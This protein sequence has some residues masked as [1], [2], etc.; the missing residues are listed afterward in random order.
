ML[1]VVYKGVASPLLFKMLDKWGNSN[2][3]ERIDLEN[4]FIRLFATDCLDSLMAVREFVGD[5]W[6]KYLNDNKIPYYIRT[7]NDFKVFI[8]HKNKEVKAWW[9]FNN[10]KAKELLHYPKIVRV[11]IQLYYPSGCKQSSKTGGVDFL[12]IVSFNKPEQAQVNHKDRWQI[13][14]CF[15]AMKVSGFDIEKTY[16]QA[17]DR[18]EKLTLLVMVVFVWCY[19]IGIFIHENI[20]EIKI[21]KHGRKAKSI[22][23]YG[24][25][26]V[27]N[28]LLNSKN[29]SDINIFKFLSCT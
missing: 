25:S 13:E 26:F 28:A 8:P 10:L 14:T 1:G 21:K 3:Q 9:L 23:K 29:Q 2:L 4:R 11:G 17:M 22:F 6:I 20:Q 24:L 16:L 7:R 15:K 12:I 27:A 18:I 5:R 19:K